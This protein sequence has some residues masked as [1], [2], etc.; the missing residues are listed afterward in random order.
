M[1]GILLDKC[2]PGYVKLYKNGELK[3]RVELLREK[4]SKCTLCNHRC[5]VNR[6]EGER[7]FC[8]AGENMIITCYG[9][10]F[11]EEKELV[12]IG[13]SGTI[14]FSYCTMKCV[15]C[16]NYDL[17]HYPQG[18]E[19][20]PQRLGDIMIE[21]Q[22]KGC[23]NINLVSPT[24]FVPQIIEGIYSAASRGLSIPIVYNTGSYDDY[25]TIKLL[26]GVIDIY[27][28]DI[29]FFDNNKG[30]KYTK[31]KEYFEVSRRAAR[32]MYRQVGDIEI[33]KVGI[34][35]KGMIVRHLVMP[36]CK[37][38]SKKVLRFIS[39]EISNNTIVHIIGGYKPMY[40]ANEYPEISNEVDL[41]EV[42][43]VTKYAKDIGL[44]RLI[45]SK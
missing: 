3:K 4:L 23:H 24:H 30:F 25:E 2:I 21:L 44:N 15:F 26:D 19:E 17:S 28:P 22:E 1:E 35:T 5:N 37:E 16:Q 14:F 42:E 40:K 10:H 13:G 43:E 29:K 41:L 8:E 27:L 20:S 12:G 18:N 45:I 32:E 38:D 7:G 33:D 36:N 11:G 39:N 9:P 34:A 6:L 31:C